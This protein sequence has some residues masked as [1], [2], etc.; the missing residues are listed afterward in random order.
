MIFSTTKKCGG[1]E[2]TPLLSFA[3]L[4]LL[5]TATILDKQEQKVGMEI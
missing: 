1:I 5:G 2:F 4:H 3:G